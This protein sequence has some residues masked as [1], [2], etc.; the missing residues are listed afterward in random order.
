MLVSL[1]KYVEQT[2]LESNVLK[3]G[4]K[5][6]VKAI[7]SQRQRGGATAEHIS[8]NDIDMMLQF[9]YFDVPIPVL[10]KNYTSAAVI[11]VDQFDVLS[12]GAFLRYGQL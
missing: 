10:D 2:G 6:L 4:G 9:V 1:I 3:D 11:N 7:F 5:A 12:S 8:P